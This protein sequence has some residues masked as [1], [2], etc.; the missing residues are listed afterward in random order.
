MNETKRLQQL[1]MITKTELNIAQMNLAKLRR[2]EAELRDALTALSVALR[3][4]AES[5]HGDPDAAR[6]AGADV[7]WQAWVEQRRR[8]INQEL[9]LCLAKQDQSKEIVARAFGREQAVLNLQRKS[10]KGMKRAEQV[11]SYYTS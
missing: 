7:N 9:A 6:I 2:R 1:A 11:R 3:D 5:S 4:R 10:V 8:L